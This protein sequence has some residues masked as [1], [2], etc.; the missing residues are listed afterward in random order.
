M[1]FVISC[2]DKPGRKLEDV[3]S[4]RRAEL[5]DEDVAPRWLQLR[6]D[7]HRLRAFAAVDALPTPG[8]SGGIRILHLDK[9]RPAALVQWTLLQDFRRLA[10]T[11]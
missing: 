5:S 4:R 10:W 3:A 1:H 7:D 2:I 8:L 9:L 6:N 11:V